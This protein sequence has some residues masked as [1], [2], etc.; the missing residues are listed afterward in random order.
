MVYLEKFNLVQKIRIKDDKRFAETSFDDETLVHTVT[1]K[2]PK[3]KKEETE[4]L[5]DRETE[6][7][8][9]E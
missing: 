1:I 2:N 9:E 7:P 6:E 8:L 3:I 5:A 4:E